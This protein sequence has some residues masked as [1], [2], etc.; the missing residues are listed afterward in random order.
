[1]LYNHPCDKNYGL[2]VMLRR[3]LL[4]SFAILVQFLASAE[5]DNKEQNWCSWQASEAEPLPQY[6]AL[7]GIS[8][9]MSWD[10]HGR[11]KNDVDGPPGMVVGKPKKNLVVNAA[12]GMRSSFNEK[13]SF[14]AETLWYRSK[15]SAILGI[16]PSNPNGM[17]YSSTV[18][19]N[20]FLI[21]TI[22]SFDEFCGGIVPFIGA[23]AGFSHN[24]YKNASSQILI[25]GSPVENLPA[26][27]RDSFAY[28]GFVGF[29]KKLSEHFS[30][31]ARFGAINLGRFS[32]GAA[33]GILRGLVLSGALGLQYNFP[34]TQKGIK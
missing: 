24:Q 25:S 15:T 28:Q 7:I 20:A 29:N 14:E 26:K 34:V 17:L 13:I 1:M 11:I 23:G 4:I 6:Y 5:E 8:Y 9:P 2:G 27:S 10:I 31:N 30:L 22:Y 18:E 33:T 3:F 32:D 16:D 19:S 21:N 12:I